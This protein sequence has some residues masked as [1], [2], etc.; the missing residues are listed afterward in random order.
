MEREENSILR[1]RLKMQ[2]EMYVKIARVRKEEIN[3]VRK[4]RELYFNPKHDNSTLN[5]VEI[6]PFPSQIQTIQ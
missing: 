5:L 2:E 6:P 3:M 1:E 4:E